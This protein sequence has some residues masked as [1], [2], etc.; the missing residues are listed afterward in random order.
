M[1]E[2]SVN[3]LLNEN[4]KLHKKINKLKEIGNIYKEALTKYARHFPD[5]S[6]LNT[7]EQAID[8]GRKMEKLV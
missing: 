2:F 8:T 6:N 5:K 4:D 3:E 7:A 1:K